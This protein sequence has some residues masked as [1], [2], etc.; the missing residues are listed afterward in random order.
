MI[1]NSIW[2]FLGT[3]GGQVITLLGNIILARMLYPDL[4]GLLGM[5]VLFSGLILVIQE[6]GFSSYIIY[7]KGLNQE[8]ISTSFW[9]NINLSL[10]MSILFY[11]CSEIIVKFF[12]RP[13]LKNIILLLCIGMLFSSL[14][15]TSRAVLTKEK[16]FR[17]LA[18][19]DVTA[20]IVS[21][22][23]AIILA[24]LNYD[25]LAISAR[26]LIL[27]AIQCCLLL[28]IN[29]KRVF[30]SFSWEIAKKI[31]PYSTKILGTNIFIYFNNNLDYFIIGKLLGSRELGL[32]TIA[33]Q[34]S[35]MARFYISGSVNKVLFP[36]ISSH[37]ANLNDVKKT[38]LNV[39]D[40]VSFITFPICFGL[41]AIGN[42]FIYLCYGSQ[43]LDSVKVLQLLVIAGAITSIG[44]LSGSL[45]QGLGKPQ[46]EL[47]F[48]ILS[49]IINIVFIVIGAQFGLIG[50]ATSILIATIVLEC[51]KT[52]L[53]KVLLNMS[54]IKLCMSFFPNLIASLIMFLTI[55]TINH[56]LFGH[57]LFIM[58]ITLSIIIG[59]IIYITLAFMI[60]KTKLIEMM[61]LLFRLLPKK[62]RVD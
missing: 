8:Y 34:W 39:T 9:L 11:S 49:F 59:I 32:Y 38:F 2:S 37:N 36:E 57:L 7:K 30:G 25:Y 23:A 48:N 53:I 19:I 56:F 20:Q 51:Y 27:P 33:Y 4:F 21:T 41:S 6:A 26:F 28:S 10:I 46:V 52:F 31:F 24:V 17:I 42:D 62:D 50:I 61:K 18:I 54:I 14:C 13:E 47:K 60:N 55:L 5:A 40:S 29:F 58:R 15:T 22:I 44:T 3:I 45:F 1:K 16:K 35:V 12:E 43:W